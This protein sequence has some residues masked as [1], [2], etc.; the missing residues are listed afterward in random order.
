[1]KLTKTQQAAMKH[2]Q[3][4]LAAMP[5][6]VKDILRL[7]PYVANK[8]EA[9]GRWYFECLSAHNKELN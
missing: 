9:T 3:N 5:E 4:Q 1:M 8:D 2:A 6:W 7:G